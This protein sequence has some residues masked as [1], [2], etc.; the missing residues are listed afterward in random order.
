MKYKVEQHFAYGWDD[1]GWTDDDEPLRFNTVTEA[2]EE[3]DEHLGM[4]AAAV[5]R[6]DM[7]DGESKDEFR[8]V[9]A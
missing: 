8:V 3:I 4:V 2:Q 5:E 1:A 9:P 6:G 7:T